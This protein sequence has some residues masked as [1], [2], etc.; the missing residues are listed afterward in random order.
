[1][2]WLRPSR[3]GAVIADQQCYRLDAYVAACRPIGGVA[4]H[5]VAADVE[6]PEG[7]WPAMRGAAPTSGVEKEWRAALRQRMQ[8]VRERRA[9]ARRACLPLNRG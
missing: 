7:A 6:G 5:G 8:T 9:K 3:G 4:H 2:I 1:M